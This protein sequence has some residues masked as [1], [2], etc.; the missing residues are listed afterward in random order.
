MNVNTLK[1]NC[2]QLNSAWHLHLE[3]KVIV[4]IFIVGTLTKLN[5]FL[6]KC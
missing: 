1:Q 4:V 3:Q 2:A 6:V 5:L